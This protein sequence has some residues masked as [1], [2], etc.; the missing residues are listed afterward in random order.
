MN[1]GYNRRDFIKQ[2]SILGVSPLLFPSIGKD[3]TVKNT[4][5]EALKA[6]FS[7][8]EF[9]IQLWTV[10]DAMFKDPTGTLTRLGK[11]GYSHIESFQGKDGIFWGMK[12]RDFKSFLTDI[13]LDMHSSHTSAEFTLD[14]TKRDEFKNLVE[15]AASI[16]VKHL[17]NPY[18]GGLKT[19]EDFKHATDGLNA[20]GEIAQAAGIEY[21]YHNHS[22]SFAPVDGIIPQALMMQGT[23]GGPVK[24]EMDIYW[25]VAAKQDPIKWLNDYPGRWSLCH[26]KDRYKEAKLQ[27]IK[28]KEGAD[29]Q[30]GI[31]G[32]CVLG[33]GQ[34]NFNEVLQVAKDQ[35]MK[36]YI[37]EQERYD[38]MTSIEAA[39]LDAAFMNTFK[40]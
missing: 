10:R 20:C 22:Y 26:V 12:A 13:N 19:I 17:V 34:I 40:V 9:G 16:G 14:P 27:E 39:R 23:E 25:V 4:V 29:E 31:N 8:E 21:S 6:G 11:F 15:A 24:F 2:A 1:M 32:S 37:V 38:D 18:M 3:M 33:Q 5:E 30:F 35:G 7:L 28:E 36:H